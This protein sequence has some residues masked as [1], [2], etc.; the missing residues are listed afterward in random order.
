MPEFHYA[1]FKASDVTVVTSPALNLVT[2]NGMSGTFGSG[3][4]AA[5]IVVTDDDIYLGNNQYSSIGTG[6]V[7]DST[8]YTMS[9]TDGTLGFSGDERL[10]FNTMIRTYNATPVT[11]TNLYTNAYVTP[12]ASASQTKESYGAS[13]GVPSTPSGA[14]VGRSV[15]GIAFN[16]NG[17]EGTTSWAMHQ[18]RITSATNGTSETYWMVAPTSAD[19]SLSDLTSATSFSSVSYGG[20][21]LVAP[22]AH[23]LG[24]RTGGRANWSGSGES[25]VCFSKGTMLSTE[26][27]SIPVEE[28]RAG[29]L[30]MTKDNGLQPVRWIR[31]RTVAVDDKTAPICISADALGTG[32]PKRDL[33]VSLQHRMIVRS[34]IAM[35][36]FAQSEVLVAAGKLTDLPGIYVD[37]SEPEVEYFHVLL[38]RHDI[39]FA[40]GSETESLFTGAHAL[41]MLSP[42]YY[43]EVM[44]LFPELSDLD[45]KPEPGRYIPTIRQQKRLIERHLQNNRPLQIPQQEAM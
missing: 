39:I 33:R 20:M 38:D 2:L 19:Q 10:Q 12:E 4:V 28:V 6:S 1:L 8:P 26:N 3:G 5:E 21:S 36:M 7:V 17:P 37:K 27:V 45:F 31:S 44:T 23:P 43:N 11:A 25:F 40:E 9:N 22:A 14:G 24:L 30:L 18:V 35:R 41:D 34:K 13:F 42:E 29:T 15:Y 16:A 32:F